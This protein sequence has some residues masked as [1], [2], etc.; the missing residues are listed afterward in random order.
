MTV[1][2]VIHYLRCK[3]KTKIK[4]SKSRRKGKGI[5]MK[6]KKRGNNGFGGPE[7]FVM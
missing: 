3:M 6:E 7:K 2:K 4:M 1:S 5:Q